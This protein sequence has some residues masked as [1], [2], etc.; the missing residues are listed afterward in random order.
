VVKATG[1]VRY[2]A[3]SLGWLAFTF[4]VSRS[5]ANSQLWYGMLVTFLFALPVYVSS[6]Y[7][8]TIRKIYRSSQFNRH[9]LLHWFSTG[10]LWPFAWRALWSVS[11]A[12]LML[13]Y[14]SAAS[15]LQWAVVIAS[16]PV[17]FIIYAGLTPMTQREFKPYIAVEKSL[18]LSRWICA[19]V[20][21]VAYVLLVTLAGDEH[22]YTSIAQALQANVLVQTGSNNSVLIVEASR[23]LAL[24][25]AIQ[26]YALGNLQRFDAW[27][28]LS[29]VFFGAFTFFYNLALGLSG[30]MVP[31]A[32][33]RRVPGA[34]SDADQPPPV[35]IASLTVTVALVS[36]FAGFIYM[37]IAAYLEFWLQSNPQAVQWL[38][39]SERVVVVNVEQIGNDFY[40]IGTLEEI[41]KA[42]LDVIKQLD[43]SL[44]TLESE[45]DIGFDMMANNVDGYLDWYYSLPGEY[46]RI[47]GLLTGSLESM[48]TEKLESHLM[49]VDALARLQD[50]VVDTLK[51]HKQLSDSYEASVKHILAQNRVPPGA[52]IFQI[53]QQLP[54][55]AV[56]EPP[57]HSGITNLE[58]RL[59]IAGGGGV[60]ASAVTVAIA[61]KVV[62]KVVGKGT[63]KLG[64][65]ALAKVAASKAAG[66]LGGSAAGAA[67][68]AAAGSVVPGIGTVVGG[69]IGGIAG[70][71][72]VGLTVDELLLML[73]E[74]YSRDDFKAQ[75]LEA[76]EAARDEFRAE[77]KVEKQVSNEDDAE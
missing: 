42:H 23:L 50:T 22:H 76:I 44:A 64:A 29:F 3:L 73:E 49:E 19:P 51:Q 43:I 36:F 6:I 45:A 30:F 18:S 38:H 77:L 60:V 41:R 70:A 4:I 27:L 25:Q 7:A 72:V 75:I 33:Y 11:F 10:R 48:M 66:A 58:N 8:V 32:E 65:K 35:T 53:A 47:A 26:A 15:R 61:T 1:F 14:L 59:L 16:V 5:L 17:L 20:M 13:F 46:W 56:M 24:Y 68:G 9:G 55:D 62:S 40:K 12:F 34:I 71:I 2:L 28:W 57:I 74:S 67:A 63:I 31:V 37:P 52:N 69:V 54:L 39:A 21:A